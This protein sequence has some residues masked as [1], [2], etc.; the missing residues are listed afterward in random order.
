M[1]CPWT[2]T[3][4]DKKQLS[5]G[6]GLKLKGAIR[7]IEFASKIAIIVISSKNCEFPLPSFRLTKWMVNEF[8]HFFYKKNFFLRDRD[9]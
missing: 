9:G 1:N 4:Q 2:L 8:S 7:I 3:S 5:P 6:I